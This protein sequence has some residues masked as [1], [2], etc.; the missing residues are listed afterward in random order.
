M[1][2]FFAPNHH[3][4]LVRCALGAVFFAS[5]LANGNAL[6]GDV[7]IGIPGGELVAA[8]PN[9]QIEVLGETLDIRCEW[10]SCDFVARYQLR[11]LG[12]FPID[13]RVIFVGRVNDA[14]IAG[15]DVTSPLQEK[16]R[17]RITALQ[18]KAN[19]D[20]CWRHFDGDDNNQEDDVEKIP[21][22]AMQLQLKSQAKEV[23]EVKGKMKPNVYERSVY[24]NGYV[25]LG[26]FVR[27]FVIGAHGVA[28]G[29]G[30]CYDLWPM[31][32]WR[33]KAK[34]QIQAQF[35][36]DTADANVRHFPPKGKSGRAQA[37]QRAE[38]R[39]DPTEARMIVSASE[40]GQLIL[41]YQGSE[42]V[43]V[44]PVVGFGRYIGSVSGY[45]R[46][47]GLGI[48]YEEF[49]ATTAAVDFV[50]DNRF[51]SIM[52]DFML[53]NV[54]LWSPA[55]YAGAGVAQTRSSGHALRV[56]F[57]LQWFILGLASAWDF[58]PEYKQS[59]F[60]TLSL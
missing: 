54:Y 28:R 2:I 8:E 52:T 43:T 38:R 13:V 45:S 20:T 51:G 22:T 4:F 21:L 5:A 19:F 50:E 46:R 49:F 56:E 60:I 26:P 35:P 42:P 12:K 30:V 47:F 9:S 36:H 23:L 59:L 57:G 48:G 34:I 3:I 31:A 18:K 41:E 24:R 39:G 25:F 10:F 55:L 44:G 16:D 17:E 32:S 27:H 29:S 15:H 1:K 7:Q 37:I 58:G 53:P 33:G 6:A 14:R 11:N 40:S